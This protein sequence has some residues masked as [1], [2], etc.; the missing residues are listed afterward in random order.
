MIDM[1]KK[2]TTLKGQTTVLFN[3]LS[4]LL[5]PTLLVWGVRDSI[6]TVSHTY[7]AAKIIPDCQL[8]VFE[9]CGHSIYRQQVQAFSQL[10]VRFLD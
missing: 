10:L 1:G 5:V 2:M 6:V 7:A 4:E 9:N 3:R 8:H